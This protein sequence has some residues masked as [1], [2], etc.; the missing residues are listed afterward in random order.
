[1]LPTLIT[2]DQDH[3]WR[4]PLVDC[5]SI[6]ICGCMLAAGKRVVV[7]FWFVTLRGGGTAVAVPHVIPACP[8]LPKFPVLE[9]EDDQGDDQDDYDHDQ[10]GDRGARLL[11]VG[12][13]RGLTLAGLFG[14]VAAV[15]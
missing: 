2:D 5:G 3:M 14:R 13:R 1:M 10:D 8:T 7:W 15:G 11:H 9:S 6:P 12:F 4:L